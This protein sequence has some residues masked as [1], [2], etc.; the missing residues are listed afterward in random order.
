MT[1]QSLAMIQWRKEGH[2]LEISH[3]L[4]QLS[5]VSTPP[6]CLSAPYFPNLLTCLA[7]LSIS[8]CNPSGK[9]IFA[10]TKTQPVIAGG[11][12]KENHVN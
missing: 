6:Y 1:P 11:A 10:T 4:F 5:T 3:V 8:V 9:G 2:P 7:S 12:F